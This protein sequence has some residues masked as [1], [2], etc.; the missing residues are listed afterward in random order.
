MKGFVL[1]HHQLTAIIILLLK[2]LLML[3]ILIAH[4][5]VLEELIVEPMKSFS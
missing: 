2:G 1:L 3:Q 5:I 4:G